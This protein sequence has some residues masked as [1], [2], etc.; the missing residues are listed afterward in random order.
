MQMPP[1]PHWPQW[2]PECSIDLWS[3]IQDEAEGQGPPSKPK[4]ALLSHFTSIHAIWLYLYLCYKPAC[5]NSWLILI[6]SEEI[7]K[8]WLTKKEKFLQLSQLKQTKKEN[9]WCSIFINR[10]IVKPDILLNIQ[11][12]TQWGEVLALTAFPSSPHSTLNYIRQAKTERFGN[13]VIIN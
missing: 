7:Y 10:T 4:K 11:Q 2:S 8:M 6:I 12:W 5:L 3:R 13:T 1:V 9:N